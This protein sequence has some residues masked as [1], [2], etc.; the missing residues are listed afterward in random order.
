MFPV[1]VSLGRDD[2]DKLAAW[3]MFPR[4]RLF[5][6]RDREEVKCGEVGKEEVESR[7]K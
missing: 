7:A 6:Y 1:A 3:V 4:V 5:G 2:N